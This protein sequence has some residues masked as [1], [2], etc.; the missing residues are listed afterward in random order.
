MKIVRNLFRW[1]VGATFIFSGFVK[2]IDPLGY[3]YKIAD[4]LEAMNLASIDSISLPFAIILAVF[5]LVI[6]FSLFF[7]QLPK[8]GALGALIMMVFF[9]PLTLW[10]AIANPVSD[11]G[12]FGDALVI[13][14][15]QTF[16]KNLVL[17]AMAILLFAQRKKMKTAYRAGVQW[18]IMFI[19]GFASLGLSI[20]C[21]KTLP[22]IDFRPYHVGANIAEGMI[23]PEDAP[24]P[25]I[26]SKFIY[27]KDG[28]QQDFPIDNLPDSTWT[29]VDAKHEI[30]DQGYVPPIHDFTMERTFFEESAPVEPEGIELIYKN[31]KGEQMYADV[32]SVP[33]SSWY[34]DSYICEQCEDEINIEELKIKYQTADG[35]EVILGVEEPNSDGMEYIEATY[36]N[37]EN[38]QKD[39]AA[40]VLADEGYSFLMIALRLDEIETEN[41]AK[42]DSI[43]KF[44][45]NNNIGFYCM[46]S[47][48][49][50]EISNFVNEYKPKY[51]FYNTDPITL[52]TIVRSNPGLLLIRKGTVIDKW[53]DGNLPQVKD[54]ENDLTGT[55]LT[56]E[57]NQRDRLVYV[58]WI[59]ST[60]LA[61][62]LIRI[63]YNWLIRNRYI[64]DKNN[65]I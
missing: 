54:L 47:S 4:Y 2:V 23:I 65:M 34:F 48:N 3:G 21:L 39:I 24:K 53:H 12:C 49:E 42:F 11:C 25:V 55:M 58:V 52:K 62:A 13:T 57:H 60:L 31:A 64:N 59:L 7:N 45:T 41:L 43:A 51:Q 27:E 37:A 38:T 33:D 30:I 15:W 16:F 19:V 61:M 26:E 17:L 28:K 1:L 44:A 63:V 10:L 29:F 40:Q 56:A 18:V 8:L 22:I 36:G 35:E 9:T 5:E 6:G 46:T 14:N 32:S 50:D 20:Y